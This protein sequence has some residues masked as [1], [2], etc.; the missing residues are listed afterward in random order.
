MD[1]SVRQAA[2][3]LRLDPSRVR[4]LLNSGELAGRR[5]GRAWV[6]DSGALAQAA[7]R[8]RPGG[9]P[10]SAPRAWGALDL[11][12]GGEAPWLSAVARSQVRSVARGLAEFDADR[13][14]AS[15][16]GRAERHPVVGH[17]AS[18]RRLA[19]HPSV[20]AA[21]PAAAGPAGLDLIAPSA[22]PELY[23]DQGAWP[24][25]ADSLHLRDE[26][27]GWMALVRVIDQPALIARL[28]ESPGLRSMAIAADCIDDADPRAVRAGWEFLSRHATA[29]PGSGR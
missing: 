9:R 16:R 27:S 5:V 23:V 3:R 8:Q 17:S 24:H 2:E 26:P 25:L 10:L 18:I 21:G 29:L 15:L 12:A 20:V 22:R 11:L 13:W 7:S 1:A 4:R 19:D 28:H 6:V 14:R